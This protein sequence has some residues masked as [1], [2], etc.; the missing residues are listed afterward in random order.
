MPLINLQYLSDIESELAQ[1]GSADA[2]EWSTV[3]ETDIGR[4]RSRNEDAFFFSQERGLWIV[5]DGMGG[6]AGGDKASKVVVDDLRSFVRFENFTEN[7]KDLETRFL[8]SNNTC[9]TMFQHETVGSTV[10][11]LFTYGSLNVFLW[12]G[13]S[14]IYRLRQGK[15]EQMTEDHNLVQEKCRR[16]ELTPEEAQ[17]HPSANILT[18]AIGVHQNLRVEME[19]AAI[20]RGDRY[21]LCSDGLYRDLQSSEI[22]ELLGS[23]E[24]QEALDN[25]MSLALDR[26]G[27]DN[28]T[29]MIV[30]AD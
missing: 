12:A 23:D 10:V 21:L 30:Q 9:R 19:Y 28:I 14:R 16:G 4:V 1:S 29:A 27:K 24:K 18:R 17:Q 20:E 13:D 3:A 22:Q 5:A 25:L 11:A 15:L 8:L 26:G 7:I 2:F 6:H